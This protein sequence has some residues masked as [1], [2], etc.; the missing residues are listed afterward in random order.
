MSHTYTPGEAV[1]ACYAM[2]LLHVKPQGDVINKYVISTTGYGLC[3]VLNIKCFELM[4]NSN[5]ALIHFF[6]IHYQY[7]SMHVMYPKFV[8]LKL[9]LCLGKRPNKASKLKLWTKI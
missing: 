8:S 9:A 6:Y 1:V 2:Q 4:L 3:I 7:M 5:L